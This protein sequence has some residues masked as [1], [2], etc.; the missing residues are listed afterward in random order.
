ME[1]KNYSGNKTSLR[2][3]AGDQIH[4]IESIS[5]NMGAIGDTLVSTMKSIILSAVA[6]A[7]PILVLIFVFLAGSGVKNLKHTWIS[8]V[9]IVIGSIMFALNVFFVNPSRGNQL[10]VSF[11][12]WQKL[13]NGTSKRVL[14]HPEPY[15][16][17]RQ[18]PNRASLEGLYKGRKRYTCIFKVHGSVSQTSF[19]DDL[20]QLSAINRNSIRALE[21]TTVR[22]IINSIGKPVIHPKVLAK[23]ATPGMRQRL[24]EIT[25]TVRSIGNAQTL[26]TYIMLDAPSWAELEKKISNQEVY[27]RQGLV[28]TAKLLA[29]DELKETMHK[30]FT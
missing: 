19:E 21:R 18:D 10:I 11:K 6:L 15:R 4:R 9:I 27:F 29:G 22:T 2:A 7:A 17:A 23:N 12:Y 16:F 30:L 5:G 8:V 13:I 25:D 28:V 20:E 3:S 14:I 26:D 24:K 1:A